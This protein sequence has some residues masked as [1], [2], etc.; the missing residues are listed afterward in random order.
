MCRKIR[1]DKDMNLF[2][3]ILWK[4]LKLCLAVRRRAWQTTKFMSLSSC[5]ACEC[6]G[7]TFSRRYGCRGTM[8]MR[9]CLVKKKNFKPV[10]SNLAAHV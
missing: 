2:L 6:K 9:P 1:C 7:C 8:T 4:G 10:T 3:K 5:D